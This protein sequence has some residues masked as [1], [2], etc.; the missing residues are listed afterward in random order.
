NKKCRCEGALVLCP[1]QSPCNRRLLRRGEHPPRNDIVMR[2]QSP[3][4]QILVIAW[5]EITRLRKR[6]AGASPL[7]VLLLLSVSGLSAYYLRDTI[8]LGNG[9]Y[10]VGVSG[11]IP[12]IQDSHFAVMKVGVE[13]GK[14]LLDQHAIDIFIN[15][16]DVLSRVDDK[17]QF[18]VRALK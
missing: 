3:M 15:G 8:T 16:E 7:V 18:A 9:L 14:I 10:R 12:L 2:S 4:N 11:D 1:K 13:E 6:F 17:S 5:R